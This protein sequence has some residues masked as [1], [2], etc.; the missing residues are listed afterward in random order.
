MK[1]LKSVQFLCERTAGDT[2]CTRRFKTAVRAGEVY[3]RA[4]CD[5]Q[6]VEGLEELPMEAILAELET[7]YAKWERMDQVTWEKETGGGFQIFTTPQR[8]EEHT[9]ELQSLSC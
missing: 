4:C 8:S 5:G 3:Q 7:A 1:A 2:Q 6:A 9:S